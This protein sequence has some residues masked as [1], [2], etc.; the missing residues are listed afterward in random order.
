MKGEFLK[1]KNALKKNKLK[2]IYR[3]KHKVSKTY[4][5]ISRYIS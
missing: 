5:S 1:I 3:D 4:K 2:F